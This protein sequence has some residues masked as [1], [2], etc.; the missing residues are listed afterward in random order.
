MRMGKEKSLT[1]SIRKNNKRKISPKTK[2]KR[3]LNI[4][5]YFLLRGFVIFSMIVQGLN[6]NW[7][8]VA[9]CVLTLI[10]F[11]LPTII[12]KSFHITFPEPLEIIVYL[13]IFSAAILGEIQNFY[14]LFEHWDTILHTLNGF[15]CAAIGFSL[16]DLLNNND[17]VHIHMSPAFAALVAF[18]FS[19]T[20][21]VMWEFAEFSVDHYLEKDMQK[22][23]I[24]D[25]FQSVK[26]NPEEENVPII[27]E[28]IDRTE[29]YADHGETIIEIEGGYLDIGLNDTMKD[30]IVNFLGAF[31][32]SI[33]GYLYVKNREGFKFIEFFFPRRTETPKKEQTVG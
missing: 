24:V 28:N 16:V 33:I 13:F 32:F 6:G 29:I 19:M 18:S 7:N 26:I 31:I 3:K 30:L 8:N 21:G 10:L 23:R 22:D 12:S 9:L 15:L 17:D 2:E 5:I 4:T 14:G 25:H 11:T 27:V 1:K 20:V